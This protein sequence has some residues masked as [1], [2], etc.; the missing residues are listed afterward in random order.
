M[1]LVILLNDEQH[2]T[3]STNLMMKISK[4]KDYTINILFCII[5]QRCP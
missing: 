5:L 3:I 2:L 4:R 1:D